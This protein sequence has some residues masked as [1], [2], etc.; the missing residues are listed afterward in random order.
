MKICLEIILF[1]FR[2]TIIILIFSA[3]LCPLGLVWWLLGFLDWPLVVRI[4]IM[5]SSIIIWLGLWTT[6]L[7][8]IQ[9]KDNENSHRHTE[10][11]SGTSIP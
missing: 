2:L 7:R 6:K 11:N 10:R 1:L 4:I 8:D 5:I 9:I 3:F